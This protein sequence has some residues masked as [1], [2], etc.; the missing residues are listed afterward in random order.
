MVP[1]RRYRKSALIRGGLLAAGLAIVAGA[2]RADDELE[3][4]LAA[5]RR[6]IAD[7][8]IDVGKRAQTAQAMAATLDRAAQSAT[9]AE[10]RRAR[11]TE[12]VGALDDFR[13]RNPGN[14]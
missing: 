12:A 3:T 6:E 1:M 2:V 5:L 11:W 14:P 7:A 10:A 13:S 4:H 9:T 8:S